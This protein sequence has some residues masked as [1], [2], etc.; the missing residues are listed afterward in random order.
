MKGIVMRT[1]YPPLRNRSACARSRGAHAWLFAL[2]LFL[3]MGGTALA[4]PLNGTY[5]IAG[6][7]PNYATIDAAIADLNARGVSGP[8]TFAI[9]SGTYTPPATGYVLTNVATM[10]AANTVTFR[11]DVGATVTI[12]GT[13]NVGSATFYLN[14]AKYFVFDGSNTVGG[15]TKDMT[16]RQTEPTYNPTFWLLNDAD[17]NVIRN[18]NLQGS[19]GTAT[20]TSSSNGIGIVF[21]GLTSAASGNDSN[22]VQNCTIGDPAGTYRNNIGVGVYGTSGKPNN[23]NKIKRCDIVNFGSAGTYGYG[24]DAYAEQAGTVVDGCT[25]HM[26]V[27]A[28]ASVNTL[29]G[30]YTDYSPGYPINSIFNGNKIYKL[31]SSAAN[32]TIYGFYHW[33]SISTA[34]ST[35][36][37]NMFSFAEN[38]DHTVY[39]LYYQSSSGTTLMYN[40]SF[41]IGGTSTGSRSVY[42]LYKSSSNTVDCRNNIFY[43]AR[44]G[45]TASNYGLY[46]SS[47]TGWTLSNYN[48]I[49]ANTASNFYTGYYTANRITFS[50]F[51]TAS[52]QEANSISVVPPYLDP[53]NGDLHISTLIRTPVESRGT[54]LG[55]VTVD[56]DG[57]ARSATTPDLGADEGNFLPPLTNDML[58]ERLI[59]PAPGIVVPGNTLFAPSASVQNA[60][61]NAQANVTVR[62][63][64][65]DASNN[66]IYSDVQTV[67]S[68]AAFN[69]QTVTFNTAGNQSG[70]TSLAAGTYTIEL[71]TQL[72]GDLDATNDMITGTITAKTPL[73][74]LYTI[75]KLGSGARN[76]T[77]FTAAVADLTQLGVT[78]Q[79]I[80]EVAAGTYDNTTET[81]PLTLTSAPG[82]SATNN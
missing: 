6:A 69:S 14:G 10:N 76:Y 73:N 32:W 42:A 33:V 29:Y 5:T 2:V 70:T 81:F 28:P 7:A 23:G 44:T 72:A 61:S 17:L 78:G 65:L 35:I 26:T 52:G 22:L 12:S 24:V 67:T 77:S 34:N 51:K 31:T 64:I 43:V 25:I 49:R 36:T 19:A 46:I 53:A 47:T 3:F 57:D 68:L 66:V 13:T 54:P 62:Y 39:G 55:A 37:N 56:I 15:T 1:I 74:G 60:G 27:P 82:M 45:G 8:V 9:R 11:P 58:A 63:R 38:G 16:I 41:Y 50:D 80:F 59:T 75:N 18:C 30:I 20:K 21:I 40:N 4:Q 48:L 71:T 79:V